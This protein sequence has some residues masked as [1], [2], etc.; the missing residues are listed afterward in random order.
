MKRH[1]FR[2]FALLAISVLLFCGVASAQMVSVTGTV[3]DSATNIPLIAVNVVLKGTTTGTNTDI[4]GRFSI[5]VPV[6]SVLVVTYIGYEPYELLIS[7]GR[8]YN[9][10]LQASTTQLDDIIVIGYSTQRKSDKTGA[11]SSVQAD[12]LVGGVLTDPMQG[13]QGKAAGVSITKKGGDPNEGFAV[14]IRGASGFNS[15]TQPLYVIDGVPGAD[16]TSISSADI[17]SV[18]ILKDAASTAIYGSRGANGVVIITTRRGGDMAAR[19]PGSWSRVELSSQ[20]SFET[21]AK[22]LNVLSAMQMRDFAQ[23]LLEEAQVNNP[24][25]TIDSVFT[26]G[27][28]STDWQ[29]EI[30]RL[31]ISSSTN[32]TLSGGQ[33]NSHYVASLTRANWEGV[34]RGTDKDRTTARL[35]IIHSALNDRLKLSGSMIASFENNDYENYSGW[36]KEDIIYQALSRNPTDPVYNPDGT[37][38][39]ASRVFNYENPI[40]IINEINNKRAAKRFLGNVRADYEILP[41]LVGSVNVGYIRNDHNNDYFRPA[42]LFASAD[43][44]FGR[45]S[46]ENNTQKLI[47]TTANYRKVFAQKHNFEFLGG[48]SWQE[49]IYSGFYAQGGDAQSDYAGPDNLA[50]LNEIKWGDIGS[51]KGKWNLIGFFG[52]VQYH[53]DSKYYLSASLRR[54]GSSK[55][56]ANNKWGWFPTVALG[57]N[58]M[59]ETRFSDVEWLDILKLRLSY[60]VAGNQEIGEYRS[61]VVWE[62]SGVSINPETGL[63]VV[64]FRPAWNANPDLKWEETSEFNFGIDFGFLKSKISGS[65][66]LYHKKTSDLLGEYTVPVPPNL[67]SRTFAN[68]GSLRNMG[69]ELFLQAFAVDKR[70]LQWKTSITVAHNS[71]KILDLGEYFNEIDGVRK[72]GYVSG[73]GLVGDESYVTGILVGEQIGAFYVPVFT[74]IDPITGRFIYRSKA[75]GFT[76]QL[77]EAQRMVIAG[78]APKAELGWSNSLTWRKKW[79]LDMAF[80]SM[81]GNHVYNATAM[82]FDNP[83]NLP[84]INA[85][86][87]AIEWREQG[88][89]SGANIADIYVENASFLRLDYV[90]ISYRFPESRFK[91][92]TT[93]SVYVAANNLFTITGYSGIDPETR[94]DGLAFGIDQFNVYPKT[95]SISMGFRAAF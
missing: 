44:G 47:E 4:N 23:T 79:T 92:F 68:S 91:N 80:R 54:D 35:S 87:E 66:E 74:A 34:M 7:E 89:A 56:G 55:F 37:Y 53:Y 14:Q 78:A 65:V 30:Y 8:S 84:S 2:S 38:Y 5:S 17:E 6:G 1:L 57:W 51:W 63:Q 72:E 69:A 48:Y 26:D 20:I 39:Q 25:F 64:T 82:F 12:E 18:N 95:R 19:G 28:A 9:I 22:K 33:S 16:P 27:G 36:G 67:A 85:L 71:S 40:A 3:T 83:G 86:P 52:R 94:I 81:I 76:D 13:L 60:G 58:M 73:R 29:N 62:P 59:N 49:S 32:L 21:V 88:R 24:D 77:S 75:G 70:N 15:N 41:G 42:N 31:G 43:N 10:R 11:V 90:A 61:L 93:M 50:V 45:K 46:Y